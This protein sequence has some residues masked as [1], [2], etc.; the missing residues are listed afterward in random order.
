MIAEWPDLI[1]KK[2]IYGMG[3][4]NQTAGPVPCYTYKLYDYVTHEPHVVQFL[5]VKSKL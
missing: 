5:L 2:Y 3:Y 1:K 4:A